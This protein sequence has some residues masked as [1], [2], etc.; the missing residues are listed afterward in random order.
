M[1]GGRGQVEPVNRDKDVFGDKSVII[2]DMPGHTPGH[3]SLLVRLRERTG[4]LTRRSLSRAP[5][6]SRTAAVPSFN[7]NRAD[8]LPRSTAFQAIAKSTGAKVIIQHEP[9][10]IA[11]LPAISEGRGMKAL[12]SHEPGGPETLR[13]TELPDPVARPRRAAGPG[14]RGGG[15]LP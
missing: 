13:L 15:Q 2:L 12:L 1:A 11:K 3:M 9:N 7:T 8:T 5:S 4:V 14:P 6:K 10:D